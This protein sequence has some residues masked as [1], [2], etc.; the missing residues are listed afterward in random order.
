M[1]HFT[2]CISLALLFIMSVSMIKQK[3]TKIVFFGDSITQA[4]VNSTG[5]I[6]RMQEMLQKSSKAAG[7]ELM[8]AGI[9]GNKIYDLYLRWTR[10]YL[11]KTL[12]L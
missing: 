9:G 6:T 12:T 10:M 4:G 5:Y 7:Y 11:L 3:K 8:G 1:K 2:K